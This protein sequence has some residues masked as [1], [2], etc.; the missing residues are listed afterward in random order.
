MAFNFIYEILHGFWPFWNA[1][2]NINQKPMRNV[3]YHPVNK[4]CL[5]TK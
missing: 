1:F 5:V 4:L 3:F 2:G